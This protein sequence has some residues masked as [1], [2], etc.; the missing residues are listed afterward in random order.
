MEGFLSAEEDPKQRVKAD[1]MVHV[2][3][4]DKDMGDLEQIS[5][6]EGTNVPQVEHDCPFFKQKRDEQPRV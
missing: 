6:G 2:R 1:E 3:M 4:G 5:K